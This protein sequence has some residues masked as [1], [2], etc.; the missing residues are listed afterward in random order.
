MCTRS[1]CRPARRS[2]PAAPAHPGAGQAGT[3]GRPRSARPRPRISRTPATWKSSPEWLAAA[4]ASS[5]PSRSRPQRSI[6]GGLHRLVRR[7]GEHRARPPGR[8]TAAAPPSARD[9]QQRHRGAWTRRNRDRTTSARTGFQ[10]DRAPPASAR[11]SPGASGGRW[12]SPASVAARST[13][14]A[15][16]VTGRPRAN[17]D[18]VLHADPQVTAGGQRAEQDRQRGAAD[19]GGRPGRAGGQRGHRLPPGWPRC[20]A[21]R[22]ARPSPGRSARGRHAAAPSSSS[23]RCSVAT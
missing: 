16:R 9:Y 23:S 1:G 6:A 5:L 8:P 3:A 4:S 19:P 12:A 11:A 17:V 20:L 14:S 7:P 22:R 21:C 13:S 15:L 2:W 18:R 10:R